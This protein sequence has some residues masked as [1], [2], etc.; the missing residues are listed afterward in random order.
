MGDLGPS[1]TWQVGPSF[2]QEGYECWPGVLDKG[3]AGMEVPRDECKMEVTTMFQVKA[4]VPD[5][6]VR[7]LVR[8]VCQPSTLGRALS[9]MV[10]HAL[11]REKLELA[12]KVVA[13]CLLA[14]T[15]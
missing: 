6:P 8:E 13:R 14:G 9:A 7:T 5:S 11:R 4:T 10:E 2:L 15:R 1:S 3:S 12:I